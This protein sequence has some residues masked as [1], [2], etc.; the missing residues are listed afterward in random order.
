MKTLEQAVRDLPDSEQEM[1][2]VLRKNGIKGHPGSAC[3]CP[4][5]RLLSKWTG[6]PYG[7]VMVGPNDAC[8]RNVI[9]WYQLPKGAVEFITAFDVYHEYPE[10]Q[11][12]SS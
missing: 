1:V 6:I 4:V 5:A 11:A 12:P 3:R 9:G 8:R 10:L 7:D 2:K